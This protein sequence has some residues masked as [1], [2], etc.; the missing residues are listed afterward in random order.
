MIR[1]NRERII[2]HLL[3]Q[4]CAYK[5]HELNKNKLDF[6]EQEFDQLCDNYKMILEAMTDEQL[7]FEYVEMSK[8]DIFGELEDYII[9]I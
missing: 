5:W 2:D 7:A 6:T 4:Y 1:L 8:G 9:A 3:D